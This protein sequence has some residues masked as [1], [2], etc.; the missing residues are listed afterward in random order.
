[1]NALRKILFIYETKYFCIIFYEMN[2][3]KQCKTGIKQNNKTCYLE[4]LRQI[5]LHDLFCFKFYTV[6]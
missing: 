1:M 3:I 2:R 4:V 6:L 5:N